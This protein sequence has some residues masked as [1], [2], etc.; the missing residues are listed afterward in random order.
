MVYGL[1]SCMETFHQVWIEPA[2]QAA[3]IAKCY[4]LNIAP[5]PPNISKKVFK[6]NFKILRTSNETHLSLLLPVG[7]GGFHLTLV[8]LNFLNFCHLNC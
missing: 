4:A 3:A 1:I 6:N 5:N 2:E 7:S 8:L